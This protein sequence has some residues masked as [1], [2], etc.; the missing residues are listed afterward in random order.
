LELH[1]IVVHRAEVLR[2]KYQLR[3]TI[4]FCG[5]LFAVVHSLSV[6]EFGSRAQTTS[7]RG[8]VRGTVNAHEGKRLLAQR[9]FAE[10]E[11]LFSKDDANSWRLAIPK[12]E[13]AIALWKGLG[14]HEQERRAV[15]AIGQLNSRLGE[16][17]KALDYFI[18]SQELC[19]KSASAGCEVAARNDLGLVY[20]LLGEPEKAWE[21]CSVALKLSRDTADR[22]GEAQAFDNMGEIYYARGNREK[23]LEQHREALS[24]WK[25]LRD[26]KGEAQALLY[27]GYSYSDLSIVQNAAES[28][29]QALALFKQVNDST[30]Q[31]ATLIA[32]GHLHNNKGERQKALECYDLA[33][34][35]LRRVGDRFGEARALNGMG[36]IYLELGEPKQA[37][38]YLEQARQLFRS[39]SYKSGEAVSL[40]IIGR[41]HYAMGDYT[42]ALRDFQESLIAFRAIKDERLESYALSY[43]GMVYAAI[44]DTANA[45]EYSEKG[46]ALSRQLKDRNR[47]SYT[48][49]NIAY[50]Q[51]RLDKKEEA[52]SSYAQALELSKATGDRPG[53]SLTLYHIARISRELGELDQARAKIE[54][55]LE[56]SDTLRT[57]VSGHEMRALYFATIH[58]LYELYVDVL[59]QLFS[60]RG[61]RNFLVAAFEASER[62]RA[63]SL[64]ETL[65]EGRANIREGVDPKLLT[66]EQDLQR[67]I[68]ALTE[69]RIQLVEGEA[70]AEKVKNL[71]KQL[72][73][74]ATE[75][76]Q[77]QGHIRASSPRYAAL[78]QPQPLTLQ[79]VQ[80]EVL[81]GDT[82]LLAYA[83]GDKH[84][85]LWAVTQNSIKHFELPARAEIERASRR[86]YDLLTARNVVVSETSKQRQQRVKS[87]DDEFP[88][89][90]DALAQ[91]ILGPVAA[92]LGKK[93][94]AIVADGAL[95]YV[96]FAAL[97]SPA[98][99]KSSPANSSTAPP[100]VLDHEI[101]LLPSASSLVLMRDEL[102]GRRPAPKTLAVV[103]DAVF[104]KGDDR[105]SSTGRLES[106]KRGKETPIR[107]EDTALRSFDGLNQG[108]Q[109]MR[110]PFS[111]REAQAIIALVPSKDSMLALDFQA[112]RATVV[113]PQLSQYR[114]VH[115]AT[116][117][118]LNSEHPDLSGILLSRYN[119]SGKPQNGFLQ[120]PDIYNLKLSADLV[121]LSA[122]QT[123][124]G[125][126]IRGEGL[127]GLTRG[128][129]YAGAPRVV[130]SLW[131][132]DDAATA[133][134]M[135]QFYT[136]MLSEGKRPAEAL[137]MAQVRIWQQNA[138]PSP[139]YWAAFTLQGEWR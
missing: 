59:M 78:V 74:L 135:R 68:N 128:F 84:S 10:G 46:L 71:E 25:E 51:E 65:A 85:F 4:Y 32:I 92:E 132:V 69:Q 55:A 120:L 114:Y 113:G 48:L 63:R 35:L 107:W 64:L 139:Y 134:L 26:V 76:Q 130:A 47:E 7:G 118:L 131:Q 50:L 109:I 126:D 116:H 28:Y 102:K 45:F 15:R 96:P 30:G 3:L 31:A 20:L 70:Y 27:L 54:E 124:L 67:R 123:A 100:L 56:I 106:Q 133:E 2:L 6:P 88:Q 57:K 18:R 14:D 93:R 129:M 1:I 9:V 138:W 44:G 8:K 117:G 62:G 5:V 89:A 83:L 40:I 11:K 36:F 94:I 29:E 105:L 53:Q 17:Q 13:Q 19:Q 111:R 103:A 98:N 91:T 136:A 58:Q 104:D 97:P 121:V 101:V 60:V 38:Q 122:C 99:S 72:D 16:L 127:V 73:A 43:L 137:R 108:A 77:V 80:K 12:Y 82:V 61:D 79:R 66:R 87:A 42:A 34:P 112:S 21:H 33:T 24:I 86:V 39:L 75:Y 81:D 90:A 119:A 49:R 110:L 95:Q 52:L 115:F 125:K 22:A 23:A 37:I 41:V